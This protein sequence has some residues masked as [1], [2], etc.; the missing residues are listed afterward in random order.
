[1]KNVVIISFLLFF[2]VGCK[3]TPS[4]IVTSKNEAQKKGIYSTP[5]TS[6]TVAKNTTST[7]DKKFTEK[8]KKSRITES[9]DDDYVPD[10]DNTSYFVKQL[11]SSAMQYEGVRYRGGGTTTGGMDCSGLVSTVFKTF[12]VSL[13]RSSNDMSKVGQKL[14]LKDV[15]KGDLIFF[16]TS[17]RGVINHVGLVTEV[18][19]DEILFIHSSVQRGVIISSTKEAYYQRTFAQANRVLSDEH[20]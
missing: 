18:R 15:K 2:L 11:I 7:T 9:A 3:S 14:K 1:M 19:D 4:G 10:D 8:T 16:K 17:N 12:D 5:K 6:Q 20:F 13:P